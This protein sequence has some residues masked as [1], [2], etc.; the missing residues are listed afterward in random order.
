MGLV[1]GTLLGLDFPHEIIPRGESRVASPVHLSE[2]L[3]HPGT[4]ELWALS[5][6]NL[7]DV[8]QIL[9]AEEHHFEHS[10][11]FGVPDHYGSAAKF[12]SLASC[13][14]SLVKRRNGQEDVDARPGVGDAAETMLTERLNGFRGGK[15]AADI[16]EQASAVGRLVGREKERQIDVDRSAGRPPIAQRDRS[17]QCVLR[18]PQLEPFGQLPGHPGGA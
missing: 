3:L 12:Y 8:G 2:L 16:L 9:A 7:F 6:E 13:A 5:A 17:T 15:L 10:Q 1:D 14:G 18:A 4:V 11:R